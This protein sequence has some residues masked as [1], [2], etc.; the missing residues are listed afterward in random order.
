MLL[1][2]GAECSTCNNF[3]GGDLEQIF[4]EDPHVHVLR[5]VGRVKNR[6]GELRDELFDGAHPSTTTPNHRLDIHETIERGRV[7][8]EVEHGIQGTL[9]QLFDERSLAKLSRAVHLLAFRCL[10]W[11]LANSEQTAVEREPDIYSTEFGHCRDWVRNGQPQGKVRPV[12]RRPTDTTGTPEAMT[13]RALNWRYAM[14]TVGEDVA[15]ELEMFL[16]QY[17]VC[18][19]GAYEDVAQLFNRWPPETDSRTW[20]LGNVM[21]GLATYRGESEDAQAA[22]AENRAH[23]QSAL[24]VQSATNETGNPTLIGVFDQITPEGPFPVVLGES[25]LVITLAAYGFR[26]GHL[27]PLRIEL[28]DQKGAV[29]ETYEGTMVIPAISKTAAEQSHRTVYHAVTLKGMT[30]THAGTHMFRIHLADHEVSSIPL[31][32]QLPAARIVIA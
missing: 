26:E 16:Q 32:V 6:R 25:Q 10:A 29:S 12:L 15:C 30:F 11:S 20:V 8:L 13:A 7:R 28:V 17:G 24:L 19:T 14:V 18:L 2:P 22:N 1:P 31:H 9:D 27:L 3:F 5:V 4:A 21:Q 23:L